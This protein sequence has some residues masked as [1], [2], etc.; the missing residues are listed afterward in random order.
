MRGRALLIAAAAIAAAGPAAAQLCRES[1]LATVTCLP[2]PATRPMPRQLQSDAEALQ[3][4]LREEPAT[5]GAPGFTPAWR[6]N[7]FGDALAPAGVRPGP[8]CRADS[9]GNLRCP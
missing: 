1:A 7:R 4:V 2:G 3:R 8:G 5:G 6:V 9:L